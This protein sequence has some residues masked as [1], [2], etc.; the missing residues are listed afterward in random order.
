MGKISAITH[1]FCRGKVPGDGTCLYWCILLVRQLLSKEIFGEDLSKILLTE[2]LIEQEF[3]GDLLK[4]MN[5]GLRIEVAEY[6]RNH[7]EMHDMV[8]NTDTK[9][10]D[11]VGYCSAIEQGKLWG[12]DPELKALSDLYNIIICVIDPRKVTK[13]N[14]LIPSYYGERNPLATECVYIYFDGEDH[15]DPL[16]LV[17]MENLDEKETIFDPNDQMRNDLLKKFIKETLK[18]N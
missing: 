16:Y 13:K 14:C 18:R 3:T 6:I 17:N 7:P 11:V 2:I 10:E 1:K 8:L 12:G 5:E 9:Y 15:F 4:E